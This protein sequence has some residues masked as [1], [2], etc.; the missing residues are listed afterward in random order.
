[1]TVGERMKQRRKELRLTQ[2]DLALSAG[3]I[4]QTIYKY[5]TG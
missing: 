1:M 5:E 3:T 4:K 2:D